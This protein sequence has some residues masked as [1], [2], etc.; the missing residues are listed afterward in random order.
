MNKPKILYVDDEP[1]NLLLFKANLEKDYTIFTAE[2]GMFGLDIISKIIDIKIVIS[3]KKMPH[4]N[5]IEFITRASQIYPQIHY[6][7]LTGFE[8]SDEIQTAL[9]TKLIRKYFQKPFNMNE[10]S[11][12]IQSALQNN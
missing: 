6:Y 7:I 9:D 11:F 8:I 4:M 1:I 5:G 10:I 3:N 12:E 2:H